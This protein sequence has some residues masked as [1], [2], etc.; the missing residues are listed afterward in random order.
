MYII[1][2]TYDARKKVRKLQ[3]SDSPPSLRDYQES[4]IAGARATDKAIRD[5]PYSSLGVAFGLGL[6]IGLLAARK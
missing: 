5:Y 4:T 3:K 2:H 1:S 6:L